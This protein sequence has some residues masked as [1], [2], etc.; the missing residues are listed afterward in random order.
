MRAGKNPLAARRAYQATLSTSLGNRLFRNAPLY[1]FPFDKVDDCR[2]RC[3]SGRVTRF[4]PKSSC[5]SVGPLRTATHQWRE[6]FKCCTRYTAFTPRAVREC[7]ALPVG[8]CHLAA[9]GGLVGGP[10]GDGPTHRLG[11]GAVP[12]GCAKSFG[13]P[14]LFPSRTARHRQSQRKTRPVVK[15]QYASRY[16]GPHPT[17]ESLGYNKP[18]SEQHDSRLVPRIQDTADTRPNARIAQR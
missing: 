1:I 12:G 5:V 7:A 3:R 16:V 10:D 8:Q 17:I 14:R 2:C 13:R 11:G 9:G 6:G 4:G 18:C 15:C